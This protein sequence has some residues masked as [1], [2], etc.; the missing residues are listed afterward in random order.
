MMEN[1]EKKSGK[2]KERKEKE[3]K[4]KKKRREEERTGSRRVI[5]EFSNLFVLLFG[6]LKNNNKKT[7]R[8]QTK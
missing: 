7:N 3:T 5:F 8:N 6:I 2:N 4:T 1:S